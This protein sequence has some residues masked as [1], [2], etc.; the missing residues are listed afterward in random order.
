MIQLSRTGNTTKLVVALL[1]GELLAPGAVH[2]FR[3][4]DS[5]PSH[6]CGTHLVASPGTGVRE[7]DS[8]TMELN[9]GESIFQA[10]KESTIKSGVYNICLAPGAI[11]HVLRSEGG[12]A[13]HMIVSDATSTQAFGA[14]APSAIDFESKRSPQ[15]AVSS[16]RNY[17]Y[18]FLI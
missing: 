3:A 17:A 13:V 8:T 5:P 16:P 12:L 7:L 10:R 4:E 1:L 14:D 11:A 2:G 9:D 18:S 15:G 6:K